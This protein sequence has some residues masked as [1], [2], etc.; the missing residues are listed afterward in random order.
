M[1]LNAAWVPL[2]N[3]I[4]SINRHAGFTYFF[5]MAS[6]LAVGIGALLQQRI[7]TL[8]MV[9][10]LVLEEAAMA[11]CV[12]QLAWRLG[13]IPRGVM[14][15]AWRYGGTLAGRLRLGERIGR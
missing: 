4:M 15:A 7:G 6:A 5:L 10:A 11:I 14:V 8:G 9:G 1:L 13:V 2:S 3:L 12:W